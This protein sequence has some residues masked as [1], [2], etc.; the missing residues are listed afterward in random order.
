MQMAPS[1]V[2]IRRIIVAAGLASALCASAQAQQVGIVSHVKIVSDKVPDVSSMDAWKASFIKP[3]M[4]DQEKALAA[5]KSSCMFVYQDAPPI[6]FLQ[7]SCVH[8][9]IK[10]FNVY[11]YGMCC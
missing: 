1:F 11:G 9:A 3:E 10:A 8:D 4:S 7:E 5:W 6:E 2:S